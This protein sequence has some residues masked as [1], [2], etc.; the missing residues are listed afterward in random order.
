MKRIFYCAGILLFSPGSYAEPL[1]DA[2]MHYNAADAAHYSAQQILK[3]LD[4]SG[5]S[6]AAVTGTPADLVRQLYQQ[7]PDRFVPLLGVYRSHDEKLHWAHDATLP[8]R[9]E[10]ELAKGGWRGIGELHLFANDRHS[11]VF[12]HIVT[13][14]E[15]YKLPLLLHADPAV[16]DTV[17]D[18]APGLPVIWAHAGTFPY[19]DLVAD[20]LQRYPALCV[21]LSVRDQRIAPDGILDDDWYELFVSYPERFMVGIDTYSTSR[22]HDYAGVVQQ[23][24]HWTRQLPEDIAAR[25]TY[26][27]AAMIFN[28]VNQIGMH[29]QNN[30][31]VA[32]QG[33]IAFESLHK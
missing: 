21:D 12:R 3:T 17:Y 29:Q 20:Y 16:I 4:N 26:L 28:K 2:H 22:W 13:L 14:A 30:N 10:A 32:D 33:D 25:L 19:P 11:P 9:I 24:R 1:F 7:A 27:N 5:V 8:A 6:Q 31:P 15:H 23:I 18:I